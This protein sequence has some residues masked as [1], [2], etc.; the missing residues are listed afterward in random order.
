[1]AQQ[2]RRLGPSPSRSQIA[3][4]GYTIGFRIRKFVGCHMATLLIVR[5]D[6]RIEGLIALT[7]SAWVFSNVISD[8][9]SAAKI[10]R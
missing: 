10:K 2:G 7:C 4:C 5:N 8:F 9:R 6:M 1:M 3:P